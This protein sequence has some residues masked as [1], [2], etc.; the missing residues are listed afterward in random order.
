[1][2]HK[3]EG[4]RAAAYLLKKSRGVLGRRDHQERGKKLFSKKKEEG[5]F[6]RGREGADEVITAGGTRAL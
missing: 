5:S 3:K 2:G 1:L 6:S 4:Q